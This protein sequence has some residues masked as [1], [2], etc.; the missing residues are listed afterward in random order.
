MVESLHNAHLFLERLPDLAL[1]D[2]YPLDRHPP[3][4]V[5][6][7]RAHEDPAMA[8][9]ADLVPEI[10]GEA[11]MDARIKVLGDQG[12]GVQAGRGRRNTE[13]TSQPL[14]LGARRRRTAAANDETRRCLRRSIGRQKRW[15][16]ICLGPCRIHIG[17]RSGLAA[18]MGR[19]RQQRPSQGRSLYT[20]RRCLLAAFFAVVTPLPARPSGEQDTEA[21][22]SGFA[23]ADCAG[24]R[25]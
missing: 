16:C 23:D 12:L 20:G 11:L 3:G 25:T 19:Q 14:R 13:A 24:V 17:W 21:G 15:R 22:S 10:D 4:G 1:S 7:V 18:P 9:S 5:V 2:D 8:A 6:S